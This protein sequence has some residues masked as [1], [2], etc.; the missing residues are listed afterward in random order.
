MLAT[1]RK[2]ADMSP[3]SKTTV[4]SMFREADVNSDGQITFVEWFQWLGLG[5]GG[6]GGFYS[7]PN[8]PSAVWG[9]PNKEPSNEPSDSE[10]PSEGDKSDKSDSQAEAGGSSAENVYQQRPQKSLRSRTSKRKEARR[11]QKQQSAKEQRLQQMDPMVTGLA[12]VL[13][14]AVTALQVRIYKL[15]TYTY[16]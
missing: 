15:P 1:V 9:N 4:E 6:M 12:Q 13:G 3:Q 5:E 7:N 14:Q 16:I 8:R 11:K 2:A 10:K